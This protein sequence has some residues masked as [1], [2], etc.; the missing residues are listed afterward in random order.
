MLY[1]ARPAGIDACFFR[2]LF[3][4]VF[5][6]FTPIYICKDFSFSLSFVLFLLQEYLFIQLEVYQCVYLD[7]TSILQIE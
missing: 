1:Y 6:P 5:E 2:L 3:Y 4:V 7:A